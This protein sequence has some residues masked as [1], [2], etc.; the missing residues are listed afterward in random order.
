MFKNIIIIVLIFGLL[1]TIGCNKI[2][3]KVEYNLS[4]IDT[5]VTDGNEDF[6]FNVFRELNKEETDGNLFIS[7]FSISTALSMTYNGADGKTKEDMAKALS[8]AGIDIST[9]NTS[10]KNLLPYLSNVDDEVD[11]DISNSIWYRIGETIKEEFI[12]TNRDAF[13][14]E[15]SEIDFS[16]ADAADRINTWIKES[17]KSKIEKMLDPPLPAD[18]VM[19]LINAVYFKGHWTY[20][21]D[22]DN[23]YPGIFTN[24]DGV[25]EDVDMMSMKGTVEYGEGDDYKV[26]RLPYGKEKLYMYFILPE[27]SDISELTDNLDNEKFSEIRQSI[28]EEEDVIV[29]IPRYKVEY[30]IKNLNDVLKKMGMASAF[31]ADADFSNIREGLFISRVLH[32][33]VIE[34]NEEGS[35]AAAVTVVEMLESAEMEEPTRFVADRPFVFAIRDEA[36]GTILFMGK[37]CK[38]K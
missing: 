27:N 13:D 6:A 38:T 37:Y 2:P 28:A 19:Y 20:E 21:F 1:L 34:V 16:Q 8:Y 3:E 10:Y 24:I 31:E 5:T 18:V 29:G 15:I 23:T 25:E 36:T 17:T 12:T 4:S 14:A 7:P 22:K 35:E 11:L 33:A 32:K 26:L 30:G 9:I